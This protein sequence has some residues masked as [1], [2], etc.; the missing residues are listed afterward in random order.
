MRET[1][2]LIRMELSTTLFDK[3]STRCPYHNNGPRTPHVR[4]W[5]SM[6]AMGFSHFLAVLV[7]GY[8]TCFCSNY[9][10]HEP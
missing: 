9:N 8:P 2:S 4:K 1:V 3:H 5:F 10:F 7:W 6:M